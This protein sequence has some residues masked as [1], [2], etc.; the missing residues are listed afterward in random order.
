MLTWASRWTRETFKSRWTRK[1]FGVCVVWFPFLAYQSRRER[2]EGIPS[3]SV[4]PSV[5]LSVKCLCQNIY[6]ISINVLLYLEFQDVLA[7][8]VTQHLPYFLEIQQAH[9][10]LAQDSQLAPVFLKVLVD[11]GNHGLP[12]HQ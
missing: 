6:S 4:F 5:F 7:G 11:L 1:S 12:L 3:P 8:Q 10:L 2:R 9:I